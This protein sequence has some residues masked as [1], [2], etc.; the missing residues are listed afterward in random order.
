ML[1]AWRWR[2]INAV[3]KGLPI[4]VVVLLL[5]MFEKKSR[6]RSKSKSKKKITVFFLFLL[7][8][9]LLLFLPLIRTQHRICSCFQTGV[10]EREQNESKNEKTRNYVRGMALNIIYNSENG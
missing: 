7:L 3:R 5:L 6:S 2:K 9:L 10:W 8:L 4:L 1:L